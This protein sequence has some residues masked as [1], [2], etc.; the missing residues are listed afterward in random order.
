MYT[1]SP[2]RE[3]KKTYLYRSA[4]IIARNPYVKL[5]RAVFFHNF[6]VY[7]IYGK[8]L[9]SEIASQKPSGIFALRIVY[10]II[11]PVLI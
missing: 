2:D 4:Y 7:F 9:S 10:Y 8:Q 6:H 5:N 11:G 1:I 3:K